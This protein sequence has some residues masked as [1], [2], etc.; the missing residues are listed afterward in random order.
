MPFAKGGIVVEEC[1]KI[2][3][4]GP[5]VVLVVFNI[6]S[7]ETSMNTTLMDENIQA[8]ICFAICRPILKFYYR[9]KYKTRPSILCV[10]HQ[11]DHKRR[12]YS[13]VP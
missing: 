6:E 12:N 11:M 4:K 5:V 9:L 13:G 2:S 10:T 8:S 3:V 1:K 7:G